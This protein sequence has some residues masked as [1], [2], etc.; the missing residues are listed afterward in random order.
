MGDAKLYVIPA[1][2]PS[3]GAMLMLDRK[4]IPYER[5]D[6]MPVISK[7]VLRAQRFPGVTVPALKIDGRRI[8]GPEKSRELDRI[9]PEP[10][11]FPGD[12]E[13]RVKVE[14]A[15]GWGDEFQQKPRRFSWWAL[16]RNRRPLASYSRARLGVPVGLAVRTG[17]PI[18][19]SPR[20]SM[21]PPTRTCVPT[22]PRF[23]RT[24]IG[25]TGGSRRASWAATS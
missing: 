24:W 10:P 16:R 6:L 13:R 7:G 22:S 17:G 4:G 23:P 2:H 5:V 11:L 18:V 8:Q 21:R 19:S 20:A 15:E 25:S 12:P 3:R 14:E 1:S 9:R